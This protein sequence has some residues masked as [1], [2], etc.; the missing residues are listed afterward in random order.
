[1]V[2]GGGCG[3]YHFIKQHG[4]AKL[5]QKL[6][7]DYSSGQILKLKFRTQIMFTMAYKENEK[8]RH[9]TGLT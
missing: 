3:K 2:G 1:M 8:E 5:W 6:I 7:G 9:R 4:S